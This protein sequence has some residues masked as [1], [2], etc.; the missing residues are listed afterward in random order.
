MA[1]YLLQDAG[2]DWLAIMALLTFF[3][4][5]T[6]ALVMAFGRSSA[7]Y[8]SVEEQPLRDSYAPDAPEPQ[9]N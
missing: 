5:F 3:F 4:V 1:K 6:V 9:T 2:I 7:S 8:R